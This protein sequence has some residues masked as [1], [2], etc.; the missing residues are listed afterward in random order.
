MTR[1]LLIKP[2]YPTSAITAFVSYLAV[3]VASAAPQAATTS[4]TPQA[5][6]SRQA[7]TKTQAHANDTAPP[8]SAATKADTVQ[9]PHVTSSTAVAYPEGASGNAVVTLELTVLPDGTVKSA[10]ALEESSAFSQAALA[11]ASTWR[12]QPALRGGVPI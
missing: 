7:G 5:A 4:S 11:A 8:A 2:R 6:A 1:G 10:R 3:P 12:F 9:P